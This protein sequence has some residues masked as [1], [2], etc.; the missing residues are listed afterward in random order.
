M[1]SKQI[2]VFSALIN[3][4]QIHVLDFRLEEEEF[5][6]VG[7]LFFSYPN[8]LQKINHLFVFIFLSK[9]DVLQ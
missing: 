3:A 9:S 4:C 1:H 8:L 7:H 6:F 2:P 5:I